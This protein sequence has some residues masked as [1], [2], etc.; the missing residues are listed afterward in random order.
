MSLCEQ[1]KLSCRVIV[2]CSFKRYQQRC[3]VV[4]PIIQFLHL[5]E[6]GNLRAT[7]VKRKNIRLLCWPPFLAFQNVF[8][9]GP[10]SGAFQR[11]RDLWW[12]PLWTFGDWPLLK[13]SSSLY[14]LQSSLRTSYERIREW[15]SRLRPTLVPNWLESSQ[16]HLALYFNW[17]V[18]TLLGPDNLFPS[19][20]FPSRRLTL[21]L[22]FPIQLIVEK[23]FTRGKLISKNL[24][25]RPVIF[26]EEIRKEGPFLAAQSVKKQRFHSREE[27]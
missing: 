17:R 22:T 4:S 27:C 3:S 18:K 11:Q 12:L 14:P 6:F 8:E 20:L 1:L 15:A 26:V 13:V 2:T 9:W 10:V 25:G 19:H 21:N 24:S 7:N 5:C 16:L 23:H